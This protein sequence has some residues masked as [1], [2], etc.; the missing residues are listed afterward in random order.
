MTFALGFFGLA[1]LGASGSA[2]ASAPPIQYHVRIMEMDGL[3]WRESVYSKLQPVTRKGTVAVWT[4]SCDLVETLQECP[5]RVVLSPQMVAKSDSVAHCSERT[6]RKV[7]SQMTR[8]ADGPVGHAIA[9]AYTPAFEEVSDGCQ[10]SFIGRK[11]DQGVLVRVVVDD[12]RLA[13]VHHVK[14]SEAVSPVDKRHAEGKIAFDLDV[15]EVINTSV[16][17][18]WLIPND[19]ILLV[20]LGAHTIADDKGKAVVR[21]RLMVI[22]AQ[23]APESARAELAHGRAFSVVLPARGVDTPPAPQTAPQT[24]ALPSRS[25]PV[26]RGA[27][28]APAPLPPLPEGPATPS[29]MPDSEEPCASPQV[30]SPVKDPTAGK[31]VDPKAAKAGFESDPSDSSWTSPKNLLPLDWDELPAVDVKNLPKIDLGDLPNTEAVIGTVVPPPTIV[32]TELKKP[33]KPEVKEPEKNE[34]AKSEGFINPALLSSLMPLIMRL[35]IAAGGLTVE[36][37]ASVSTSP[38]R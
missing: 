35:P 8:H 26:P 7:A 25:L 21:E 34:P 29:T 23:A 37:R 15:P 20:S 17:G 5:G 13:A 32:T 18:E 22:E 11:L 36:V 4:G 10:F 2:S 19:G 14:L 12:T 27:D 30:P 3:R 38:K 33:A 31:P 1:L 16:D 28:G 6:V 24:P 9:V